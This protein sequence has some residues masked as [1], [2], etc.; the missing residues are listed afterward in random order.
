M[1]R[2]ALL[3]PFFVLAACSLEK[4][5][6]LPETPDTGIPDSGKPD[7][8]A[9]AGPES[10]PACDSAQCEKDN[11]KLC[12]AGVC[13]YF[14]SCQAIL[15]EHPEFATDSAFKNKTYSI[16]T[17]KA[18]VSVWC[19]MTNFGGG[20][21]LV[22]RTV[23]AGISPQFGWT[24][25]SGSLG[26]Y[27]YAFDAVA[28]A[29]PFGEGLLTVPSAGFNP[30]SPTITFTFPTSFSTAFGAA[31]GAVTNLKVQTPATNCIASTPSA[32]AN[33]GYVNSPAGFFFSDTA[34]A[35]PVGVTPGGFFPP[36][37]ALTACDYDQKLAGQQVLL[38]VR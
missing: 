4:A 25:P 1:A 35:A 29:L 32:L 9:D 23:A 38:F 3:A 28:S 7:V 11:G 20:W 8:V 37:P 6:G 10:P 14:D 24:S 30:G 21:T 19:D 22:A 5:G 16:K 12:R 15:K 2:L 36:L 27:P 31:A 18:Q 13:G 34:Q 17:T 33:V 26:S